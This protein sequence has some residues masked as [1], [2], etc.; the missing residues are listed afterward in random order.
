MNAHVLVLGVVSLA[1]SSCVPLHTEGADRPSSPRGDVGPVTV[2]AAAVVHPAQ[3]WY[4]ERADGPLRID[5]DGADVTVAHLQVTNTSDREV[6]L[7]RRFRVQP[8]AADPAE[9]YPH[10]AARCPGVDDSLIAEPLDPGES[11]RGAVCWPAPPSSTAPAGVEVTWRDDQDGVA[12][13]VRVGAS[14]TWR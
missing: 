5:L 8:L 7:A 1:L 6:D 2:E 3:A 14:D 13:R 12:D 9:A 11:R 10:P 4:D